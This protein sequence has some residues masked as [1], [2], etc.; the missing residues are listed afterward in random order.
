MKP[1]NEKLVQ[2]L[3]ASGVA[4]VA[5]TSL[6]SDQQN[7]AHK[8]KY[9]SVLTE[10]DQKSMVNGWNGGCDSSCNSNCKK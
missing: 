6:A 3:L 2:L 8:K 9:Y 4:V 5:Q 1:I 7:E 10:E